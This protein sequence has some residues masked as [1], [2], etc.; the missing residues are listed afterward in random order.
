[1]RVPKPRSREFPEG[2]LGQPFTAGQEAGT[3][4]EVGTLFEDGQL[5]RVHAVFP[6]GA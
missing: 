5:S 6:K 4:S 3:P 2:P 1:M